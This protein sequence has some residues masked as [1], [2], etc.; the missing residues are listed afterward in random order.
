[1]KECP[2]DRTHVAREILAYLSGRPD[3][4]D[5]MEGIMQQ[6]LPERPTSQQATLVKEVVADLV[7]QGRI[8]RIPKEDR[9]LYRVRSRH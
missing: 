7:T 1:M 9:T 2:P 8:E 4:E 5:T 3:A 6:R